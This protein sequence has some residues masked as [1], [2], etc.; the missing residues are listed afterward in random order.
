MPDGSPSKS[1][2]TFFKN[3]DMCS[4]LWTVFITTGAL[5]LEKNL[6]PDWVTMAV[7]R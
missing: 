1:Q 6:S 3:L 7:R 4:K 5:A 2:T